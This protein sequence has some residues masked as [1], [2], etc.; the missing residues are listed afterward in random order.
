MNRK[1]ATLFLSV[2]LLTFALSP[3]AAHAFASITW[4]SAQNITGDSDVST[5]GSLLYAYN[6]GANGVTATTV[7]G[8]TFSP[9]VFPTNGSNTTTTGDVAFSESPSVLWGYNNLGS[10]SVPFSN[11]SANYQTLLSSAGSAGADNTLS[12]NFSGLTIGNDYLLQWWSNDSSNSPMFGSTQA[13]DVNPFPSTVTLNTNTANSAGA[14]GQ[15]VI[16]TFTAN[17]DTMLVDFDGIGGY[18]LINA[19]QIRDVTSAAVPEPGQVAAS[20]LL[21]FGIGSYLWLKHRRNAKPA[22]TT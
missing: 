1:T 3:Q 10:V 8:V 13:T 20:I 7:N 14:T 16:G 18:P 17:S 22:L 2:A 19:F 12:A 11:L 5:L 9:Y 6:A 21:L 15:Y 4:G